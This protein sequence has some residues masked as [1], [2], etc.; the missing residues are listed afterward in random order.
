[1]TGTI[2][3]NG[4]KRKIKAGSTLSEL[5]EELGLAGQRI[6][7]E[8]NGVFLQPEHSPTLKDGDRIELVR[9]VGGG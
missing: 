5:L 4:E 1:M 6:A 9:F 7:V 2:T 8:L 3:L